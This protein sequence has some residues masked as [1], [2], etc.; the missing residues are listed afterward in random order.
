MSDPPLTH[1]QKMKAWHASRTPEQRA[2]WRQKTSLATTAGMHKWHAGR[3]EEH[4][5]LANQ[6]I[7]D[8]ALCNSWRPRA[9]NNLWQKGRKPVGNVTPDALARAAHTRMQK[10]SIRKIMQEVVSDQPELIR[11]CLINGLL[12]RP[13]H[14]AAYLIVAAAY[15]DGRPREAD[16]PTPPTNT[17]A[18]LTNDQLLDRAI[19]VARR[20]QQDAQERAALARERA[21]RAARSTLSVIDVTPIP[22]DGK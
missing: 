3:T 1:S 7:A 5:A 22:E 10:A 13:P 21:E 4:K 12:A 20:L 14:S 18:E 11:D 9:R 15:L 6:R 16:P 17:L 19:A 8:A 2:A